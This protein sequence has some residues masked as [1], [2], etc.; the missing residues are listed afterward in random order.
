VKVVFNGS[1][2]NA[3]RGDLCFV[4][5]S[6]SALLGDLSAVGRLGANT[7]RSEDLDRRSRHITRFAG[8]KVR[9]SFC[10]SR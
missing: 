1:G 5:L 8:P 7:I 4:A 6:L 9:C 10:N 2:K 3:R